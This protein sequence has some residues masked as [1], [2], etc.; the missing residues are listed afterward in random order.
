MSTGNINAVVKDLQQKVQDLADRELP[1]QPSDVGLG[2]V[3]NMPKASVADAEKGKT[4]TGFMTPS[5]TKA[6][7]AAQVVDMD[8]VT[9]LVDAFYTA[10][11]DGTTKIQA[12][13]DANG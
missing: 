1:S 10:F 12:A 8:T 5:T 11:E 9:D 7:I 13:I 2:H 4:N 3:P 6:A